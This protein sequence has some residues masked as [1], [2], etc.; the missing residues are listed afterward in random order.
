M[1]TMTAQ[2]L[3]R[4][5]TEAIC[6]F[7]DSHPFPQHIE[8][9]LCVCLGPSAYNLLLA[10]RDMPGPIFR[11]VLDMM[12]AADEGAPEGSVGRF[13]GLWCFKVLDCGPDAA[14]VRLDPPAPWSPAVTFKTLREEREESRHDRTENRA[15]RYTREDGTSK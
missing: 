7:L 6:S 10:S 12:S 14:F 13:M 9:R 2:Q 3:H 15:A 11:N 4:T 8:D 1:S 5:L